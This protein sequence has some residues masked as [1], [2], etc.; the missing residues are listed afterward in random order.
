M[1]QISLVSSPG[2][3][4][5]NQLLSVTHYIYKSFNEGYEV[6]GVFL[7]ISKA[8]DNVCHEGIIFKWK[9]NGISGNL[10]EYLA[11]FSKDE[12]QRVFL[13]GLVSN[14]S[15]ITAGVSQ[16]IVGP[17]LFLICINDLATGLF[18]GWHIL[19]LCYTWHKYLCKQTEYR[20][21]WVFDWAFQ[22]KMNFNPDSSKQA[23]EV[24]FKRK[25]KKISHT[26]LFFNSIQVPQS[27]TQKH[28]HII[29]DDK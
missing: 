25:L 9:Q 3:S 26:P 1:Q 22:W 19:V 2:D 20:L 23:Q 29:F 27:S 15:D 18:S 8:F 28:L 14:W 10:L 7:D 13:N 24:I 11:D 6:R 21:G 5:I 17:L 12:K 4:C 16:A